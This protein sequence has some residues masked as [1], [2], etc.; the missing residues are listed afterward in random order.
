MYRVLIVDDEKMIR[1]GMKNAI[2]WKKLG[3]DDVFTAASG[4][5]ALK[6]LKEEG[7]E[8]M[9]TDIQMTE[10]TGLELIKAARESVPELRVIVLTGFDNFEYARESLRLQVQD[11]FLKPIDEDDLFNAI[12]KQ[13][14]EL[15]EQ[16]NKEQNQARVWR[17]Q[18]SVVQMRLEQCMRNLVHTKADKEMQLYILQKDF[19]FDIKQKMSLILLEQGMYTE[20]QNDGKF[21]AMTVKNV[22][23]SMVDSQ[24]RGITFVDDDGTI[25][26]VC[27]EKDDDDSVLEQ[28]EELSDVLKDEF[29]YKPKITVGSAVQGFE[30]LAI[31][32]NDARYLLE[33]EKKNIQDIIQTMGA[34][35]KKKIF[36]EIY[37]ELRNIMISNIGTPDYVLKAFNTF[38][39]ATESY[40]LSPS[41]V[42][43]CCFEIA[44]SLI[45]SYMEVSCE[46]EE[47]KLDALSKSLSSAGKEEACEITRMFIEQLIENDEEDV[48]YTISNARHYIDEHLAEDISVSSIAESLY[49]TPNYFSRLF[50]RITGEGCNEFEYKPKITVG[51]AVQGFE[52]LAI[53]YNDARYLLEHEKKNIQDIIQTMGAQN[54]KKIFWEIYAE[55]RNIMISNIGT[56]DYVLKAFNTFIKATESYNLSPSAVRRCCFEIASSLIFSYMEVSCEVEEGKL[57]ALSKSL[58]SAGKEEA[59]EI[60]RMFIEQ[61]IENDEEDVHY[62]IS[63]ARHYIDEH[64][65]EDISVS[66]IAE[67]LYITPNYFSRLFKRITGEGCNEYIVR[68]RIEKAKSLLETTS[69]KTGK[70]AMMVGYRD[71]NYFS[72]AFKKHT[73]K[74]PTKYREEMQNT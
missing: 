2:D 34:Q 4:N 5:E 30:N 32:Y 1:M 45:F 10:M 31:S 21:R 55:L 63:N 73:G 40:N 67:S 68:K 53:S 41:A 14:K 11:F 72:L 47:G 61:L 24:N 60:T 26:I 56:P 8:I 57:D 46:V 42:R 35:N 27:F 50:K 74:S 6:I 17:S 7:P 49:I 48:H 66:S 39:K 44:S 16:E 62:T 12:E 15:K 20:Q 9:V 29:E 51:S 37:A 38:I 65:A 23:M 13:I 58:S 33:H 3:V 70:I 43:R 64:L 52:N 22:C 71:T 25:A 69:I 18:G 36:W 19:Q 54:K 59:C 28:I